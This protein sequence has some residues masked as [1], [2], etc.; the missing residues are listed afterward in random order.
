VDWSRERIRRKRWKTRD[1]ERVPVVEYP[2]WGTTYALLVQHG[3]LDGDAVLPTS[4]GLRRV[5]GEIGPDGRRPK[6]EKVGTS[7]RDLKRRT[8]KN[9]R[10]GSLRK[11]GA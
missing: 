9:M 11:A 1:R 8:G 5:R 10:Q 6:T 7:F 3:R 4:G 2:L